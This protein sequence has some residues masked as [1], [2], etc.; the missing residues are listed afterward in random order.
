MFR[1]HDAHDPQVSPYCGCLARLPS[2]LIQAGGDEHLR[3]DAERFALKSREAGVEV[4]LEVTP[5]MWHVF[6]LLTAWLPEADRSIASVATFL[7]GLDS[8]EHAAES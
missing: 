2:L 4:R 1:G 3:S 8:Q 7:E 5:G 6:Q